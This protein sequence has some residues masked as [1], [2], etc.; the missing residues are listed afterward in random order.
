MP[1][2]SRRFT[3]W[4]IGVVVALIHLPGVRPAWGATADAGQ[5]SRPCLQT[6]QILN[7]AQYLDSTVGAPDS[8]AKVAK[9]AFDPPPGDTVHMKAFEE[10]PSFVYAVAGMQS[11][12]S[13]TP[14]GQP[15]E[16]I[17]RLVRRLIILNASTFIIDDE[18]VT[19]ISPG[20]NA[21][22]ISSPT[23]PQVSG[24]EAHMAEASR[25]I[26]LRTL[27]PNSAAYQVKRAGQGQ[28]GGSYFLETS[29]Q[30]LPAGARVL[31]IMHVGKTV[32]ASGALQ[33]ELTPTAGNWKLTITD[34]DRIFH[35]TLPPP[36]EKAGDIAITNLE[37]KTIV[38]T[39][40]LPSGILPH[41]P[42][43]TR[44]LKHWDSAYRTGEAAPWDIGRPADELQK[45]IS[46]GK[47]S[48]CRA[49]D[50]CCGSGTDAIFL[51]TQGFDVTGVD[52][53]PTALAQAR[54]KANDAK[55]SVQWIL[56]DVLAL[57]DLKPFDFLYDRACYHVV[58][59]QNQVAYIETAK[60]LSHPGTSFLLISARKDDPLADGGWG[61]TEEELRSDFLNLFD[62][63]SMHEISL[64]TS[65]PGF[66][67]P[68]WSVFLKRKT[69]N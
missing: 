21:E 26:S 57:P 7:L 9:A 24:G 42:G 38:A 68:A 10:N 61:V 44:L 2:T 4:L 60:Q 22:C 28:D 47:I 37:G 46:A 53:S 32:Q 3:C 67:P 30:E 45:V 17:T 51:A 19:P 33:S 56:A 65:R 54:K 16:K 5:G 29:T 39:R 35:L 25:E 27:F 13:V 12:E 23:A 18:F 15:A 69:G 52:V 36:A 50:L 66:S 59:Q 63:D 6:T 8:Y 20:M 62:I 31:Q 49:V 48:K 40:P 64:E 34:V 43:G 1:T 11:H 58:R 41:G 14:D 55:V